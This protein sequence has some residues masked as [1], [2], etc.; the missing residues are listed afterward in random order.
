MI[1]NKQKQRE[2]SKRIDVGTPASERRMCH[3]GAHTHEITAVKR[4]AS[5]KRTRACEAIAAPRGKLA[6]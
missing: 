1:D 3:V 4:A 5:K 6:P 2:R